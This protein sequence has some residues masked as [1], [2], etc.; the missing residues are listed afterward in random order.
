MLNTGPRNLLAG[1]TLAVFLLRWSNRFTSSYWLLFGLIFVHQSTTLLVI[2][3]V[4]GIDLVLRPQVIL[5][6]SVPIIGAV[7]FGISRERVWHLTGLTL[8][9]ALGIACMIPVFLII[10]YSLHRGSIRVPDSLRVW[11]EK[12]LSRRPEFVEPVAILSIWLVTL[13]LPYFVNKYVDGY[14][15]YYFWSVLHTRSLGV[16]HPSLLMGLSAAAFA[17]LET[18][19]RLRS[20]I[21]VSL[22]GGACLLVA[23]R[24]IRFLHNPHPRM[25]AQLAELQQKLNGLSS[26]DAT[27]LTDGTLV[28]Y[29]MIKAAEGVD[30]RF[31]RLLA[32]APNPIN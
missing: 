31:E 8:P 11:R 12:I 18:W 23:S 1:L 22:L 24:E 28:Y 7:L 16:L 14:Q 30:N 4:V 3:T 13:P 27:V 21:V 26:I 32:A 15:N 6:S 29:G 17:R 19:N 2:C 5:K 10:V 25:F 20:A 9:T